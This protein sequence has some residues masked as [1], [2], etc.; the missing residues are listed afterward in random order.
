MD[1]CELLPI[2]FDIIVGLLF[3]S[4]IIT[5]ISDAS[6]ITILSSQQ[7]HPMWKKSKT[8]LTTCHEQTKK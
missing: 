1:E 6:S 2:I 8:L 7:I 3:P 5:I 4:I